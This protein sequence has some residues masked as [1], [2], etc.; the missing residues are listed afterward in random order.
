[1]M[2]IVF[3]VDNSGSMDQE[4]DLL[5]RSFP[6]MID[7]LSRHKGGA[8]DFRVAVTTTAFNS[9][10][11]P[12]W[13]IES[14]EQGKFMQLPEM[15]K[16]WLERSDPELSAS[17]SRL[18]N[19]GVDGSG[20]EQSLKA[21]LWSVDESLSDAVNKG[22]RRANSLLA[23]VLITDEDDASGTPDPSL[24][25]FYTELPVTD[26]IQG[27]DKVTGDRSRWAATVIAGDKNCNSA[28]GDASQA[29]RLM[30]FVQETGKN[31][32]FSSIC[33]GNFDQALQDALNTFTVA[34]DEIVI[35]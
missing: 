9:E 13:Q 27:L 20:Q 4:Q 8:L 32:T 5:A 21:A 26:I 31:A 22:F 17:F 19:V 1:M 18:A 25:F 33:A 29:T 34:C 35:F 11:L 30:D 28:L 14:G 16:A 6:K 12:G 23:F 15:S 7:V 3:V 10:I 24:P 2:D